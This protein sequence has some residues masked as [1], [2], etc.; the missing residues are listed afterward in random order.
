MNKYP[1][2]EEI[3]AREMF[4]KKELI[5]KLILWKKDFWNKKSNSEKT[6]AL[7]ILVA[8]L[9]GFHK[10]TFHA[11]SGDYYAY[12]PRTKTIFLDRG[13]PSIISTLH[14][15]AHGIND[16]EK[17]MRSEELF[18]CRWSTFLF[19]KAFPKSFSKL[20]WEGHKLIKKD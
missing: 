7:F 17:I 6:K 4:F 5:L 11:E 10:K 15:F 19:R 13:H 20:Y 2:K 16:E 3:V 1:T 12:N 8:L 14:E 9:N 18:A